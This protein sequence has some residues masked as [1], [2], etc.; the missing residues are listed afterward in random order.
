MITLVDSL[1][2]SWWA[3]PCPVVGRS[4]G[5]RP[6]PSCLP[7]CLRGWFGVGG[8]CVVSRRWY[9]T[10][11]HIIIHRLSDTRIDSTKPKPPRDRPTG[12]LIP[13]PLSNASA[14]HRM[15]LGAGGRVACRWW[16][17]LRG[18]GRRHPVSAGER[19]P[20]LF[21]CALTDTSDSAKRSTHQ[22]ID[23]SIQQT[24]AIKRST[25][26]SIASPITVRIL[27]CFWFV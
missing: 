15:G 1:L 24:K 8:A 23:R 14:S 11:H 26:P 27:W 21:A 12:R 17:G 5:G 6:P 22:S 13:T 7:A 20:L 9:H 18:R 16:T 4:M 10:Y 3:G 25:N 19:R 2:G